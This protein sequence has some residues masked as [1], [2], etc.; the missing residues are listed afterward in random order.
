M[1]IILAC[2]FKPELSF[3]R[4]RENHVVML[5]FS[6]VIVIFYISTSIA[7][8]TRQYE[9]EHQK[10]ILLNKKLFD[11][12]NRDSL[13]GLYNRRYFNKAVEGSL[14]ENKRNFSIAILDLDNFKRINDTYGHNFGDEVLIEIGKMMKNVLK[15]DGFS[16]RYGGEEFVF[17][18]ENIYSDIQIQIINNLRYDFASW[19]EDKTGSKGSFSAGLTIC[20]HDDTYTTLLNRADSCL[21]KAKETGKNK[22]IF[23]V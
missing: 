9:I 4:S 11:Q 6:F 23:E 16:C 13:T 15:S 18:F 2:L 3:L 12:A 19:Y 20:R 22:I 8:I 1:I 7:M 5:L 10:T 21:Y 14:A 17:Y